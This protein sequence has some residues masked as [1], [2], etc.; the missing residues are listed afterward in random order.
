VTLQTEQSAIAIKTTNFRGFKLAYENEP[1]TASMVRSIDDFPS[2]WSPRDAEPLIIDGG[3]NIGVSVLE[4][5]SRWPMARVIC[6]EPDPDA[7]RLLEM[8]IDQ[9]DI[10]GVQCI[11]AALSDSDGVTNLFGEFGKAADARGNSIEQA[12]GER[13]LSSSVEVACCRLSKYLSDRQVAFLKLD[14]EGAEQ[15][16]LTEIASRL[17][18][19][20]AIYVEVH[21]TDELRPINSAARIVELL[22]TAGF[23]LEQESRFEQ[24]ALPA[25][26]DRWRQQVAA[27]QTQLFAWR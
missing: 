20:D 26:L 18:Q 27:K 15:R 22:S 1:A 25:D 19:V 4:W 10:P 5:K 14:I 24:H 23:T 21:E 7:F 9:N 3:A 16:V 12:W 2:F 17:N 8:N 11:N 6:F 13:P